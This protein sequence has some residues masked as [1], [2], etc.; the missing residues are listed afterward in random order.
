MKK[1]CIL[2]AVLMV[3][4]FTISAASANPVNLYLDTAPNASGSPAWPVF[5]DAAYAA[6]YNGT[7]INQAN[8][9]N[10]ANAG[11][12]NYEAED[13][14]VY[15]FGDLGK[16][17]HAFYY[18]PGETI[19]SLGSRFQVSILYEWDGVWYNPYAPYGWGEWVTPSSWIN[20]DGNYDGTVDGVMGPMGN[21]I[22]GAYGYASDTPEARAALAAD[23]VDA[24]NYLGN[25]RFFARL[26]NT[27]FELQALHDAAAVPEPATLLLLGLG[28]VGLAGIRRKFKS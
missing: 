25:T 9:Y 18:I 15:S 27:T 26:D 28:M 24:E 13:Y 17:L 12:L 23:L 16:R 7:F 3:G 4:F 11:T 21:A 5:R 6:I 22:W 14:L 8:S 20:Y 19:A 10:A 2:L 1:L